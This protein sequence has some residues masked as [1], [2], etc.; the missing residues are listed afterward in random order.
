VRARR[1]RLQV[2]GFGILHL[3]RIS[4]YQW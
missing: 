4:L 3:R 2:A 1:V